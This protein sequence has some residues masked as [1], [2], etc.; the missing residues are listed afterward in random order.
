MM[1]NKIWGVTIW[2]PP[3]ICF[4]LDG[5]IDFPG[6]D[7]FVFLC[8]RE[9]TLVQGKY[10]EGLDRYVAGAQKQTTNQSINQADCALFASCG[11]GALETDY[12]IR[13]G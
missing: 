11:Y 12:P 6:Y 2:K 3:L 10:I 4:F 8:I 1:H 9:K 5:I 7:G 13:D